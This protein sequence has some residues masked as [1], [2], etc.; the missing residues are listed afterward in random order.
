MF[1]IQSTII[2]P[3]IFA[4]ALIVSMLLIS[5]PSKGQQP[6]QSQRDRNAV[7]STNSGNKAKQP[8]T[9][10]TIPLYSDFMGVSLGMSA[11]EAREKLGQP[12]DKGEGHDFF[13]FS[14]AKAAQ[15]FYDAQGKVIAISVDYVGKDSDAPS[16]EMILGETVQ[17]K[18]D[19]S[20]YELK[21]YPN[22]GYWVAYSRTAGESPL[23]TVTI[24]KI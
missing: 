1:R 4:I 17:P 15:V 2:F 11:D 5:S 14:E 8:G 13:I 12:K 21:R 10:R 23:T 19:G 18:P 6:I 9:P 20:M 22:E 7:A 24:Q 16:P 3:Y